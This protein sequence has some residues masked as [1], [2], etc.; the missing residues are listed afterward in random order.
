MKK[1][2]L[3]CWNSHQ[4]CSIK[5][6]VLENFAKFTRKYVC[7]N[8]LFFSKVAGITP[9]TILRKRLWHRCFLWI[10][11]NFQERLFYRTHLGDYSECDS[12]KW[13]HSPEFEKIKVA[14]D[15]KQI[16]LR[17]LSHFHEIQHLKKTSGR[18]RRKCLLSEPTSC[19]RKHQNKEMK[20][21][22]E[23]NSH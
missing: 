5:K 10:L 21:D 2:H 16:N 18:W 14:R 11:W 23:Y 1:K 15:R 6:D 3:M 8:C 4:R 17:R 12:F 22:L 19:L 7:Q 9:A 13:S 20:Y